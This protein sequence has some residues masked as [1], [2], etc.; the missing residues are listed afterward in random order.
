MECT[1]IPSKSEVCC[2]K[3]ASVVDH[4][5]LCEKHARII[6]SR[7]SKGILGLAQ[8]S[9]R[10]HPIESFPGYCYFALLPD[11][12]IKIGYSNT[13]ELIAHRMESLSENLGGT[14]L[15]L[16]TFPGGF[17]AESLYHHKFVAD[18]EAG[19][20]ETFRLSEDIMRFLAEAA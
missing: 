10:F 12:M 3:P 14:V 6:S 15:L 11:G 1:W 16:Q 18:R 5:A 2:G 7:R 20:G 8:Q 13:E 4:L 9:T 17:V 19:F